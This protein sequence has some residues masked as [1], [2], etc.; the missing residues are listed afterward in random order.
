MMSFF[1]KTMRS[2]NYESKDKWR[3]YKKKAEVREKRLPLKVNRHFNSTDSG[4]FRRR[5][6]SENAMKDLPTK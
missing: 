2:F 6:V 5:V 4:S 1:I 3:K